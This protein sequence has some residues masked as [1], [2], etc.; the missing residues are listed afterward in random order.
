M[1]E[2]FLTQMAVAAA[3]QP[4][5]VIV[6]YTDAAAMATVNELAAGATD[7]NFGQQYELLPAQVVSGTPEALIQ[8][9]QSPAIEQIW[10]DLPVHT[11]L[12]VSVPKVRAPQMW[13]LGFNGEGIKVAVV[14]TG[15]DPNHPDFDTRIL[16][17]KDFIAKKP[18]PKKAVKKKKPV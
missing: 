10:E 6:R 8:L 9:S 3:D 11:M 4:I 1:S 7:L 16:A 13:N 12:D 17:I 2:T 14:D 15:I 18:E 5:Q